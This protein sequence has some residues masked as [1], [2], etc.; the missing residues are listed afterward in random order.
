MEKGS[1]YRDYNYIGIFH[2]KI[3]EEILKVFASHETF[4]PRENENF[5]V[6]HIAEL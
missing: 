1:D 6:H 4:F 3:M 5:I 2:V